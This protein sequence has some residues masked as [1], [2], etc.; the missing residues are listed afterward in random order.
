MVYLTQNLSPAP[1]IV[2]Q[3]NRFQS[4]QRSEWAPIKQGK[5]QALTHQQIVQEKRCSFTSQWPP[6]PGRRRSWGRWEQECRCAPEGPKPTT[7]QNGEMGALNPSPL[8]SQALLD[9]PALQTSRELD[10]STGLWTP[11]RWGWVPAQLSRS[12]TGAEPGE[13]LGFLG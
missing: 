13:S 7:G 5:T 9:L 4:V 2:C 6:N 3:A 11:L 10:L 8:P 12:A 1:V